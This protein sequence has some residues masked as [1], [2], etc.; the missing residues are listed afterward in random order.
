ML[1]FQTRKIREIEGLHAFWRKNNTKAK[2]CAPVRGV[3]KNEVD[4]TEI[5]QNEIYSKN[6]PN[7][8]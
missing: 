8:K 4:F 6:V 5:L 3:S 2:L 1:A 7:Q